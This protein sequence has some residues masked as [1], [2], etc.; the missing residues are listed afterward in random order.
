MKKIK[1]TKETLVLSL[2][3]ILSAIL[4]FA[5]IGIEGYGNGYYAAGV[6]SM[7]MSLKNFFF[8]AFDP[9]GFVTVD[10]PPLGFMIQTISAKIFGF[11]GWSLLLPQALAGV[12]S[13]YLIYYLVKRSFGAAAG[14]ISA[15]CL[16]VTPVFVAASRNNTID[17]LLVVTLL[18][19]CVAVS[20]AAEKGKVKFLYISLVLVGIGFNIKMLEAYMIGPAIYITYLLSSII[21]F[22]KKII[23]LILGTVILFAVSLSWAVIVDLV[24]AQSRPFVGSSTNN[25][26]MELIIGHNGLER[27]GL[28]SKSGR[29][30]GM[31]GAP[32]NGNG[33][34]GG[35][36]QPPNGGMQGN[37]PGGNN[38]SF[39]GETKAGITRLFSNNSLSDQIVWFIPLALLGFIAG[40]IKEKLGFKLDNKRKLS[41]VLW[42]VWLVPEFIYFSYTT[43]LFHPYYLTMM[44]PPVAALAGIGLSV[45]WEFYKE[46]G[47]KSWF[48]PV[49]FVME[50]LTHML[51]LS[52][53][54]SRLSTGTRNIIAVALILGFTSSV[55]L[56]IWNILNFI[57]GKKRISENN[58]D[59]K[60]IKYIKIK[61]VLVGISIIGILVTPFI[62]ASAM[63]TH[64]LNDSIPSAGLELLSNTEK[65]NFGGIN[66]PNSSSS[67]TKLYEFLQS[68][69]TNE[70]YSLVVSSS[71]SAQNMIIQNGES[72]MAL[73]GFSGSDNILALDQFKELVKNGEVRYVLSGGMGMKGGGS[74]EIMNWVAQNGKVVSESEWKDATTSNN[75]LQD[76]NSNT[77]NSKTQNSDKSSNKN[78]ASRG[79]S[80]GGFE[81]NNSE[82][83]YDLKGAA[84]TS[85]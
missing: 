82:Q 84:D 29:G 57:K 80:A 60:E 19:A 66:M 39:G 6:K 1:F 69:K 48:L 9:A 16:S 32:P 5:N 20:I 17:N 53:Y 81:G 49:A 34:D 40:A 42:I 46:G 11:S 3:L 33:Q 27:L 61:K 45:M 12:I 13:V 55:I 58:T 22:K 25:S 79:Q 2:I 63:I 23:H 78:L 59:L 70:K 36:M 18:F 52:Y 75:E 15:L 14:L 56:T 62:G 10:K 37:G 44:A 24:P 68:H 73:G 50:G 31:P 28:G 38:G 76:N 21:S 85:K 72:V 74:S 7:T 30:T 35:N 83:L 65:S 64:K 77:T 26:V 67:D 8:V 41:L 71:R 47:W 54:Y 4:N 43:G 51:M